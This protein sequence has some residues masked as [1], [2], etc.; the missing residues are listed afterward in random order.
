M[1]NCSADRCSFTLFTVSVAFPLLV[2]STK[3]DIHTFDFGNVFSIKLLSVNI[4]YKIALDMLFGASLVPTCKMTLLGAFLTKVYIS[5][6]SC[7]VF[8]WEKSYIVLPLTD[9]RCWSIPEIIESP[10]KSVVFLRH[11]LSSST[12]HSDWF[13]LFG[14]GW[15][16]W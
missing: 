11:L 14:F 8:P 13:W 12:L 1:S 16:I 5:Y 2:L 10:T 7:I 3:N 15:P 6:I 9:K 4:L